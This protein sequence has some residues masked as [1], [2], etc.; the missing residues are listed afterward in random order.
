MKNRIFSILFL[1]PVLWTLSCKSNRSGNQGK[2]GPDEHPRNIV[3]IVV[4]DLNNTLGCYDHPLVQTPNIDRLADHGLLF[5]KAYNNFAVCNPSRSSFLTGLRPETLGILNNRVTLKSVLSDRIT[6]PALFR[7]NGYHTISIG[8]VFNGNSARNDTNAWDEEYHFGPTELGRQGNGR[9]MTGGELP[10]C[11]WLEAEGGDEDQADG[12]TAAK[13]VEFIRKDHDKPFFMGLGFAKPHDPFHAPKKYYEPYPLEVCTPPELPEGWSPAYDHSL[14]GET[15]VFNGF[16]DLEKREFLRSYY[17]CT[18]FMDAQLGKVLD[19]LEEEGLMDNTMI[20][21]FGDHGY[22]LGEHNWWNKVT[23]YEKSHNSPLIIV[24]GN[25]EIAGKETHAMVEFLDFYPTLASIF[26]LEGVPGYL[27]GKSFEKLFENPETS[28]R[29]HVNI[30]T[31]R[32]KMTGRSVKTEKWRYIE[33]DD[34]NMGVELYDQRKDPLEYNNLASR[35]GYEDVMQEMK[36]L[37]LKP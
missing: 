11:R 27:E 37:I 14:P 20:V 29:D 19:A 32:G 22:H 15:R 9:N 12:K 28:F 1:L 36:E 35:P 3:F 23:V 31:L 25:T 21:F 5:R 30:L 13:A 2:P 10:W 18:S 34:G 8:K 6:L 17:A 7:Q 4:D 16:T 26:E 33:W 24:N